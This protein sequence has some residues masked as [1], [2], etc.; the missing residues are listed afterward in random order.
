LHQYN[1]RMQRITIFFHLLNVDEMQLHLLFL[2]KITTAI[3]F[4]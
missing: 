2:K 1:F 4:F 3:L